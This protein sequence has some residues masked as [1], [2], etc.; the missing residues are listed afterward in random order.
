MQKRLYSIIK[1]DEK[2]SLD[3]IYFRSKKD[4]DFE[5]YSSDYIY[6]FLL[7]FIGLPWEKKYRIKDIKQNAVTISNRTWRAIRVSFV[8]NPSSL[9]FT[10]YLNTLRRLIDL[11]VREFNEEFLKSRDLEIL[12]FPNPN[13]DQIEKL[14]II[15]QSIKLA[16]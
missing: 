6:I 8:L 7:G 11:R 4:D 2:L 5:R 13:P 3:D 9:D 10:L 16:V 14:R 1:P 15:Q 12:N